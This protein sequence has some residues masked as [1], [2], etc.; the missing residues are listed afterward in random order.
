MNRLTQYIL[1]IFLV[2]MISCEEKEDFLFK[3]PNHVVF[4][5]ESSE[6]L[7]S[8]LDPSGNNFNQP[9]EIQVHLVSPLLN[10]TT[11]IEYTVSGS[12]VEGVDYIIDDRDR[13]DLHRCGI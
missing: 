11:V 4:S 2:A 13:E 3:G 5:Q 9:L 6:I 1:P 10:A 12:A 7:E 8:H